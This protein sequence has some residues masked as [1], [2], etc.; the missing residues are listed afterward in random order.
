LFGE[1]AKS[2]AKFQ[3]LKLIKVENIQKTIKDFCKGMPQSGIVS[4]SITGDFQKEHFPLL[5]GMQLT[6]LNLSKSFTRKDRLFP[7]LLREALY[8]LS[9]LL[10][11]LSLENIGSIRIEGVVSYLPNLTPL[12]LQGNKRPIGRTLAKLASL[13]KLRMLCLAK[14]TGIFG[15]V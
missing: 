1:L 7:V 9:S 8:L 6:T 15:E 5:K 13:N 4:L 2:V 10:H 3:T 11:R 14:N 12:S